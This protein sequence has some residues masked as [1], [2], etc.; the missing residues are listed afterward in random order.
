MRGIYHRFLSGQKAFF[1]NSGDAFDKDVYKD[2]AEIA[3][4]SV[5]KWLL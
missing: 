3:G 4:K 2:I 1:S 5:G